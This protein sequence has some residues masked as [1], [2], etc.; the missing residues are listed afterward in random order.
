MSLRP[1]FVFLS[2]C[3]PF[4]PHIP[5]P[6]SLTSLFPILSLSTANTCDPLCEQWLTGLGAGAGLFLVVVLWSWSH[7]CHLL[8]HYP[9]YEQWLAAVAWV[10]MG[11]PSGCC[12]IIAE[13]GPKK[14]Q[15][16]TLVI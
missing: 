15:K 8:S 7:P 5:V 16:K 3:H 1:Y 13:L 2:P 4:S 12:L 10:G 11:V 6:H 9:P 14:K